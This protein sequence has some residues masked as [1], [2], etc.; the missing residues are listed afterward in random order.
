MPVD[1]SDDDG[2]LPVGPNIYFI[3]L[4]IKEGEGEENLK[5]FSICII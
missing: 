3:S 2:H 5:Y 1:S 4:Y